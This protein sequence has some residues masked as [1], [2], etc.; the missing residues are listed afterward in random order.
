MFTNLIESGADKSAFKRRSSFF[1]VT[2]AAYTL[3]LFSAAIAG[4][5]TYDARVDAQTNSLELLEWIPPVKPVERVEPRPARPRPN[6]RPESPRAPVDPN[7]RVAERTVAITPATDPTKIPDEIGTKGSNV[8]PVTGEVVISNRN[9]DPPSEPANNEGSCTNCTGTTP[10]PK[11]EDK[12][13]VVPAVKETPKTIISKMIAS[14]AVS[15]PRPDYPII[16][17]Q[18]RVQ[19]SVNVQ[20][21]V[22]ES[23]KVISAH[24]VKGNGMLFRAAEDAARRARFTPTT[25]NSQPVKV[26]GVITYNFVLQ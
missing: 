2:V 7:V 22:D 6:R 10:G 15:L 4:V 24:A 23:G 18:A 16:A 3:V 11:A 5:L 17:K 20:I 8:P 1:A 25:L 19:G 21:L 12:T 14:Q 26:Q 13:P 9:V